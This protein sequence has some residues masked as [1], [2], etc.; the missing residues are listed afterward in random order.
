MM[1][2]KGKVRAFVSIHAESCTVVALNGNDFNW[3]ERS[4]GVLYR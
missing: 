1:S 3:K 4:T 2:R